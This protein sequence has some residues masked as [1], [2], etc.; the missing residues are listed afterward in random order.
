MIASELLE[1]VLRRTVHFL[2]GLEALDTRA[3]VQEAGDSL[4]L[5]SLLRDALQSER[6]PGSTLGASTK[7]FG[8]SSFCSRRSHRLATDL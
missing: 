8:S 2:V 3:V 4:D 5:L 7:V 6:F 1:G